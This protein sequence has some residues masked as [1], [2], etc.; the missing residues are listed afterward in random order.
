MENMPYCSSVGCLYIRPDL[1]HSASL[2]S[3]FM[4]N[5]VKHH[6]EVV[7]WVLRYILRSTEI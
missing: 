6:W 3:M 5:L 7:K 4:S 2:V 1:S